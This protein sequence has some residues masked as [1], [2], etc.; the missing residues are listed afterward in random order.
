[1]SEGKGSWGAWWWSAGAFDAQEC[2]G[3]STAGTRNDGFWRQD[4][5]DS[6]GSEQG[7][8]AREA[9]ARRGAEEPEVPH[10]HKAFGQN[11]LQEAPQELVAG[12]F[13]GARF[14]ALAVRPHDDDMSIGNLKNTGGIQCGL[15]N[16][17]GEI[18]EGGVAAAD[19]PRIHVPRLAPGFGGN[20]SVELEVG[21]FERLTNAVAHP[22]GQRFDGDKDARVF[23][24]HPA[25]GA[26]RA[27]WDEVVDVRMIAKIARPRLQHTGHAD[28]TTEMFRIGG[29]I[30]ERP[31]AFAE[32]D[33][34][35]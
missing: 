6:G 17:A 2:H 21:G 19:R 26:Q 33:V 12:E 35:T 25:G 20:G 9:R 15:L 24:A 11:M 31:G 5:S 34:V 22:H 18:T 29:Q 30:A 7:A 32:K 16:V 4:E 1:M 27:G 28:V 10:T 8:H 23:W 14:A 13:R 3:L